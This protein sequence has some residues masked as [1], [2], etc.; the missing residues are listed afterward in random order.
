MSLRAK[1]FDDMKL[2][3]KEREAGKLRLAVIRMAIS[4]IRNSEID[5]KREL[6]DSEILAVLTKEVKM[7]R[8]AVEDFRTAKRDDL[9]N[10]YE[11]EIVI[12]QNYLPEQL[13]E[14]EITDIVKN[15]IEQAGAQS[16]KELG[17][18]MML[19]KP[20]I[21]GRADGKLVNQ[22]VRQNLQ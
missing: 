5:K 8:D 3:M 16:I 22:I 18:V 1:L 13:S 7:R 10:E 21:S 2:A 6:D 20:L 9:V 4:N 12:L 17:K 15:C 11:S 19:I 14:A